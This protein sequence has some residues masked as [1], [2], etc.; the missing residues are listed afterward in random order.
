MVKGLDTFLEHFKGFE[1]SYILIGGTACDLWMSEKDLVFRTTKDLDM[2]IIVEG[3]TP[4][5]FARF[6]EF[7]RDGGYEI[8]RNS[9]GEAKFYRFNKPTV[10]GFPSI[11]ELFSKNKF[12]LP[13]G[14]RLTPIPAGEDLSSL[15]ALLLNDDCYNYILECRLIVKACPIVPAKCLMPLK[16]RAYLDMVKRKGEGDASVKDEDIKKHRND[17]FRLYTTL[18]ASDRYALPEALKAD[19]RTFLACFPKESADWGAVRGALGKGKLPAPNTVL[20]QLRTIFQL[21][22]AVS[23]EA[24]PSR[25]PAAGVA[26]T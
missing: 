15:S 14:K 18:A 9:E 21:E 26:A 25:E 17:V 7:I 11:I 6:W 3:L 19:L 20:T 2:V 22:G 23:G 8:Q 13:E 24:L 16:A 4:E 5:F 10:N 1:A 12:D